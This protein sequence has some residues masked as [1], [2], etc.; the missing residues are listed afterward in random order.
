MKTKIVQTLAILSLVICIPAQAAD[1]GDPILDF[2]GSY[3]MGKAVDAAWDAVTG[4]PDVNELQERIRRLECLLGGAAGPVRELRSQVK[5]S[6]THAEY[7]EDARTAL[8]ALQTTLANNPQALS[9]VYVGSV[10]RMKA[11]FA[12]NWGNDGQVTGVYCNPTRDANRIYELTGNNPSEGV[13]VLNEYTDGALSAKISM[14]KEVSPAWIA[15]SGKMQNTDGR[16]LSITFQRE[17][18]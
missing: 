15:W 9:H 4:K 2:V 5:S 1:E 17:R 12:L 13:L 11:V 6:T 16:V 7:R 10:G 18:K 14:T 8:S 3:L